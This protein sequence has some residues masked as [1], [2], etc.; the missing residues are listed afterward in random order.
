MR[1]WERNLFFPIEPVIRPTCARWAQER[2]S[3]VRQG[4]TVYQYNYQALG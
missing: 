3:R 2:N 1:V 4:L